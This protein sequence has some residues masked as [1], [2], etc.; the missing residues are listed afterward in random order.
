MYTSCHLM[1]T[2]S[3]SMCTV[4]FGIN[5]TGY[6]SFK[7]TKTKSYLTCGLSNVL[8]TFDSNTKH[9]FGFYSL[10]CE[11]NGTK[12]DS[13]RPCLTDPRF[14]PCPPFCRRKRVLN[15]NRKWRRHSGHR[16]KLTN[17]P[18]ESSWFRLQSR[19]K[20][21]F[22]VFSGLISRTGPCQTY[23]VKIVFS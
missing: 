23:D 16:A 12:I 9:M 5:W 3:C 20:R 6:S 13:F 2:Q 22:R 14:R 7:T 21:L 17:T 19:F 1:C 8:S 15:I 4:R 11:S 10:Y 18:I